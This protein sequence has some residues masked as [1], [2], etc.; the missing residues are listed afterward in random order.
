MKVVVAI[1]PLIPS[2]GI[3][4]AHKPG[5]PSLGASLRTNVSEMTRNEWDPHGRC[6]T[7]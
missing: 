5:N 2:N 4:F 7:F 6:E 3:D 1:H